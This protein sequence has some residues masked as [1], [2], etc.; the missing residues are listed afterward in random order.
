MALYKHWRY[1]SSAKIFGK[2]RVLSC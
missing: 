1:L 2:N